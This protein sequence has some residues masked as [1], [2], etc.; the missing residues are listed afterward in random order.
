MIACALTAAAGFP[1]ILRAQT[2]QAV[3]PLRASF[4]SLW[5]TEAVAREGLRRLGYR[6]EAP[7]VMTPAALYQTLAQGEG[8]YTMDIIMPSAEAAYQSVKDR[9]TLLG[10]AANP[11]S[12]AGYLIDKPTSE[13]YGIRSITNLRD[14]KLAALFADGSDRRARLIGPGAGWNDEKRVLA[15]MKRLGLDDTVNVLVGEYAVMVADVIARY[16]AG[17]PVF[18]Y[19]WYPNNATVEIMPG[20]DVVW[21]E[22]P[23]ADPAMTYHGIAGC[24][25]GKPDCLTGW[26]PTTYYVGAN[27]QWLSANKPAEKFLGA[28]RFSLEDRVAQNQ[29]MMKGE[30][31]DRD[32]ARHAAEWIAR[33][34]Q[35]FDGW[36]ASARA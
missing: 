34:Q 2:G 32:I 20:R 9:V 13:K 4:D 31:S 18:F 21:L 33:N 27:T 26:K 29:R 17:K 8:H 22:E 15:D 35:L 11:G 36:I 19:A 7:S 30:K 25:S 28:L 6:V 16:R 3:R 5:W 10:P 24:A 12:V 23:Q 1:A 14:P